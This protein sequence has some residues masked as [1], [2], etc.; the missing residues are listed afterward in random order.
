MEV[1]SGESVVKAQYCYSSTVGWAWWVGCIG[2]ILLQ[3]CT[4]N[5]LSLI[6][7]EIWF[8]LEVAWVVN[9]KD[10]DAVLRFELRRGKGLEGAGGLAIFS[11]GEIPLIVASCWRE[12]H[13]CDTYWRGQGVG[14]HALVWGHA[15]VG[16]CFGLGVVKTWIII[17]THYNQKLPGY[18]IYSDHIPTP[19][20]SIVIKL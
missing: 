4:L 20:N 19:M 18:E 5:R 6:N 14:D 13:Y 11:D 2:L 1:C 15:L 9:A 17:K 8:Q 7:M 3:Y 12:Y 10:P 16:P